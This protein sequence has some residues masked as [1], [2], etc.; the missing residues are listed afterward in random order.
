MEILKERLRKLRKERDVKQVELA[1]AIQEAR[2]SISTYENGKTPHV[3]VCIKLAAYFDV[4]VD[5]LLCL[6]N[7]RKPPAGSLADYF[8]KLTPYAG[9]STL[10]ASGISDLLEALTDYYKQGA[11]CGDAPLIS[12]SG[13]I[14]NLNAALKAAIANDTTALMDSA[15]AAVIAA[16]EVTKMPVPRSPYTL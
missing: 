7:D 14:N 10:T 2:T 11:P 4:T 12:M 15:N 6:T 5:Y 9:N 16:L 3:D 1:D 13:Y 8:E